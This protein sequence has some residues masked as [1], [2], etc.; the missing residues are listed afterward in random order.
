MDLKTIYDYEVEHDPTLKFFL[1]EAHLDYD[2]LEFQLN[3]KFA[4]MQIALN[5]AISKRISYLI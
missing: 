1:K 5:A 2:K 3:L 4:A